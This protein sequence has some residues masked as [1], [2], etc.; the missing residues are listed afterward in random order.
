MRATLL[1]TEKRVSKFGGNFWYV[2]F[3]GEDGKSYRSC[4]YPACRNFLRWQPFIGKEG[5]ELEGLIA[6]GRLIDADSWPKI[7]T[8]KESAFK[9]AADGI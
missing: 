2:F 6:R 9:E 7:L 1:K 5:V 4:L 8:P 3:K